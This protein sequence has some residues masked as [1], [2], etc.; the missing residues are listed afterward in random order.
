MA[1]P[2]V[3]GVAALLLSLRPHLALAAAT[4]AILQKR[5]PAA[6]VDGSGGIRRAT[7]MEMGGLSETAS[8]QQIAVRFTNALPHRAALARQLRTEINSPVSGRMKLASNCP[9]CDLATLIFQ[10]RVIRA[11]PHGTQGMCHDPT[12]S[13]RTT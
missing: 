9:T 4:A 2:Y 3:A 6:P 10:Q 5:R 1:A 11:E 13:H 12:R 7:Q 8:S